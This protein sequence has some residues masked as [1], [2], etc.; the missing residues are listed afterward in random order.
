MRA[1][2]GVKINLS[3]FTLSRVVQAL[4]EGTMHVPYRESKL[5]K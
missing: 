1:A 2:E 5:T 3:L 4:A